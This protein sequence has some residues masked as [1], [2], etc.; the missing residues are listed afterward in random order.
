MVPFPP[1]GPLG[2]WHGPVFSRRGSPRSGSDVFWEAVCLSLRLVL[3]PWTSLSFLSGEAA[4]DLALAPPALCVRV[5]R[6]AAGAGHRVAVPSPALVLGENR[7]APSAVCYPLTVQRRS[8]KESAWSTAGPE[9]GLLWARTGGREA[10]ACAPVPGAAA[11]GSARLSACCAAGGAWA[12]RLGLR[13]GGA[14][15]ASGSLALCGLLALWSVCEAG[16]APGHFVES[17][18]AQDRVSWWFF[19]TVALRESRTSSLASR[20]IPEWPLVVSY[21]LASFYFSCFGEERITSWLFWCSRS[22]QILAAVQGSQVLGKGLGLVVR[23]AADPDRRPHPAPRPS[24]G[25]LKK[26]GY[27]QVQLL[28][29]AKVFHAQAQEIWG[30]SHTCFESLRGHSSGKR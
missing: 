13:Q 2:S 28:C 7:C 24:I 19:T 3:L 16:W 12:E 18:C 9:L 14:A 20:Q 4:V 1:S 30:S 22:N 5:S 26:K 17:L 27:F 23:E 25:P 21:P 15:G 10:H 11:W 6:P 8:G 29:S